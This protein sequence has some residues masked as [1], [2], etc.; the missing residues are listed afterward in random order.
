M[1]G[2]TP[3]HPSPQLLWSKTQE[4]DEGCLMWRGSVDK[5]GY[6]RIIIRKIRYRA[7]RV[8]MATI[9]NRQIEE[10][11][12][13]LHTCDKPGCILSH[14]LYLGSK[15]QN[16][17]D[18]A[19]RARCVFQKRYRKLTPDQV[20]EIRGSSRSA[21]ELAQELG[22]SRHTVHRARTGSNYR[23]VV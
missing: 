10:T 11:E 23:E 22:V 15:Q 9:L 4:D 8:A 14:H 13:V 6:G 19:D 5:D 1:P 2:S 16:S 7:P 21:I 17:R 12:F 18:M 3:P 20:R